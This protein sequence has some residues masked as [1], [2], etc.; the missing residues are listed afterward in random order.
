MVGMSNRGWKGGELY[1]DLF[2]GRGQHSEVRDK[3]SSQD[4][5]EVFCDQLKI[6]ISLRLLR[7]Q[8]ENANP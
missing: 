4:E 3:R 7:F 5:I 6:L 2:V 8:L 1:G